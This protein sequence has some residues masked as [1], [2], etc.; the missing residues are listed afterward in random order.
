MT[1]QTDLSDSTHMDTTCL[2]DE[3]AIKNFIL[4]QDDEIPRGHSFG[5][6][7]LFNGF[8]FGV[9]LKG[10]AR[11]KLN[12]HTYDISE[13]NIFTI[14][15]NRIF[16]IIETSDDF[17]A[18]TLF[19]SPNFILRL[20]LH[21]DFD[22]LSQIN[23]YPLQ[24]VSREHLQDILELH[25]LIARHY[26]NEDNPYRESMTYGFIYAL[27]M[28]IAYLYQNTGIAKDPPKSPS[29]QESLTKQFF[30]LLAVNLE[31]ERSV[32]FYAEKLCLTP[33]YLSM[34]VKKVTGHSILE[35]INK[36]VI[37]EAK[38]RLITTDHTV[39]EISE[40]LNF[41]NPSFF[42]RFFKQYTGMTPVEFRNS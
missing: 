26:R 5:H 9:C 29:R 25:S 35:W 7:Y 14:L 13:S 22:L 11:F 3:L 23:E 24:K 15:P 37:I 27:L 10:N 20:P 33:K 32:A 36:A 8:V 6:P 1:N 2:Q 4:S 21:N 40:E 38:K 17:M 12:Y 34:T 41:P 18:E 31:S 30:E 19:L 16:S 42:G 39:L 28:H